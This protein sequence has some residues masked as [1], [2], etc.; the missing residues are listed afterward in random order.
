MAFEPKF[1]GGLILLIHENIKNI[2]VAGEADALVWANGGSP[3][4]PSQ[5][6]RK[7]QWYNTLFPV[8][9]IIPLWTTIDQAPDDSRCD[10]KHQ[11]EILFED[12]GPNADTVSESVVKRALGIDQLLRKQR[13]ADILAGRD[14]TRVGGFSLE[15][16][17]HEYFQVPRGTTMYLQL[18]T[19][20]VTIDLIES[21]M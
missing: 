19:F 8:T 15:I 20:T 5:T 13:S 14:L 3:M 21:R 9:S 18:S 16:S 10:V 1:A 7:S 4:P 2:I 6:I 17:R 11:F 12:A